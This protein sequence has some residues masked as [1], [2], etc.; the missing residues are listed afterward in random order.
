MSVSFRT[1]AELAEI[2]LREENVPLRL[3]A[4]MVREIFQQGDEN[5]R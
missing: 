5:A 2:I 4:Q 1:R 3:K